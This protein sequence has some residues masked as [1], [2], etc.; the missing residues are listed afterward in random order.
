MADSGKGSD[1]TRTQVLPMATAG[2]ITEIRPRSGESSGQSAAITPQ[3]S[4]IASATPRMGTDLT[5]P[6]NLS[7]Q[8]A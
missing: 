7:A 4:F 5:A 6:S 8:A 2:A 1:G 3:G